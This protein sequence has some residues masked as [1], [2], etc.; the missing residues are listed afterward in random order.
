MHVYIHNYLV[1][2]YRYVAKSTCTQQLSYQTTTYLHILKA[3][4]TILK[5]TKA[6]VEDENHIVQNF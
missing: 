4:R 1:I 3:T 5:T 6:L 2:K